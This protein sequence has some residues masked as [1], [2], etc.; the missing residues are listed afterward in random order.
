M[1]STAHR[2]EA[3]FTLIEMIV[4]IAI[5]GLIAGIILARPNWRSAG[6]DIQATERALTAALRL[7]RSRA[8]LLDRDVAVVTAPDGFSLDG[9]PGFALPPGQALTPVRLV[10]TPDGESSGGTITLTAPGSRI[11]L[12]VNWLTGLV[13]AQP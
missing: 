5:A 9:A 4:V 3:G 6:M 12:T 1:T 8:I 2:S 11:V 13:R 10:F 7:A